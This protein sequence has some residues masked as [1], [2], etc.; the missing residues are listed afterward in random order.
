MPPF[1]KIANP[2]ST[3]QIKLVQDSNSNRV[4]DWLIHNTIPITSFDNLLIF[5]DTVKIFVLKGDLLK[6]ITNKNYNVD[7]ASLSDRK[8]LYYCAK[9]VNFDVKAI[10]N[11]STRDRTL[12]KLLK[13]PAPMASGISTKLLSSNPSELCNKLKLL[14]QEKEA[15][16]N[17]NITNEEIVAIIDKL[18]E[19]KCITPTQ[20]KKFFKK[21]ILFNVSSLKKDKN[22]TF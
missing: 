17:S 12:I 10:G 3:S 15:G 8:L 20:H 21:F 9:E 7:L 4:S 1:S 22:F 13:S 16:K 18:L 6:M 19:Y 2:E 14:L 5:R 11:K